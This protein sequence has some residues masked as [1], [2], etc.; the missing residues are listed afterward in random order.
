[1]RLRPDGEKGALAQSC[2]RL[3]TYYNDEAWVWEK[4]A[5]AK[6]RCLTPHTEAGKTAMQIMVTIMAAPPDAAAIT[7]ALNQMLTR[8]RDNYTDAPAWQ[9]RQKPGGI[10]EL[11]LL[12]QGCV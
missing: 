7:T 8:F 6:A 10:R 9:L 12:V 5:L 3:Q 1:M 11:D 2:Q 4:M